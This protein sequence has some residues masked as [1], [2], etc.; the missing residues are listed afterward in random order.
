M[1]FTD[2]R[3]GCRRLI[4]KYACPAISSG[5]VFLVGILGGYATLVL[6]T[7]PV[8]FLIYNARIS[9]THFV[10]LIAGTLLAVTSLRKVGQIPVLPS[11]AITR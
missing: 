9:W 5:F 10:L 2:P 11:A 1:D 4:Y 8:Q 3:F 6:N 7:E